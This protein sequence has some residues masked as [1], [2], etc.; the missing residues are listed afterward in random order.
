MYHL[1]PRDHPNYRERG[2]KK[3]NYTYE[4]LASLFGIKIQSVRNLVSEGKF[5]P[6]DLESVF[7]Y[8]LTRK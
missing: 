7:N 3:F 6:S 2:Y 1:S 8:W 4:D 5:N